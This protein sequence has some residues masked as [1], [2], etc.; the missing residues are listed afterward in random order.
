MTS[1]EGETKNLKVEVADEIYFFGEVSL[2]TKLLNFI[3]QKGIIL[4]V[5]NYYGFYSGSYC[6]RET[7][8]SGYLLVQQVRAYDDNKKRLK[9]TKEILKAASQN[10]Y[11]NLRYYNG[12][13]IDL[14]I[15][16]KDINRLINR[17]DYGES[18]NELMGIEGNIRK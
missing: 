11:R 13:G 10:I 12:R 8:I 9:L 3:S 16:M 18:I 17:L 6:P 14:K 2:N 1:L 4:H 5:F 7:N 15:P